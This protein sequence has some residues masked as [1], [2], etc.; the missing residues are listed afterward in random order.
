MFGCLRRVIVLVV[1]LAIVAAVFLFRDRLKHEWRSLRGIH[2]APQVA[3]AEL[4]GIA[5]NKLEDL[6]D[7]KVDRVALGTTELQSLIQYKYAGLLPAFAQ[8]P[9]V[10]LKGDHVVLRVRVPVD[11]LPDVKGLGAASAFLP[12]TTEISLSGTLIPLQNG[13]TAL[14]VDG[15]SAARIPLPPRMINDGLRRVGRKNEPGLPRDAIAVNLPDGVK[16]AY[17]RNDSLILLAR[18]R[19]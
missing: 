12:D 17:I 3:T 9:H 16:A 8:D 14:G 2:D 13:R 10:E 5:A 1:V 6:R 11:K 15:V 19:N 7:H 18:P 4:G